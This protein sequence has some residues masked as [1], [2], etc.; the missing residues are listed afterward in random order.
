MN[1][2]ITGG[3]G[4]IGYHL[5]KLLVS[6]EGYSV[7]IIDNLNSYYSVE[8]KLDRLRDLGFELDINSSRKPLLSHKYENLKFSKIDI[9]HSDELEDLFKTNF[10]ETVVNLAAQAGVRY[11]LEKPA[12]YIQSNV[13]GFMN[14]L[15]CCRRFRISHLLYASSSSVYGLNDEVPLSEKCV[16]DSP[17]S[18]YAASKKSNELMAHSYSYLFNIRTTGLR[19]FTVYGPWGRP[20]MA[21]FM[22][23]KSILKGDAI[24]VY[25]QGNMF[26]DFTFIDDIVLG[27]RNL[28]IV[29][30]K[31]YDNSSINS[32][33][34]NHKIPFEVFNIGNSCPVNLM[35]F[36]N[37]IEKTLNIQAKLNYLPLQPGDVIRTHSNSDKLYAFTSFRP[38]VKTEEGI[39]K[40]VNWYLDYY[41]LN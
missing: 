35:S 7:Y 27:I 26:R 28:I 3:A 33:K 21:L 32:L 40:F 15:E 13:L 4:F 23:V 34:E 19:F 37:E 24:D 30:N 31:S 39:K 29:G 20:D 36:I 11:S 12:D 14:V 9:S 6:I 38:L 17:I 2:L 22:F 10:F 8:L 41:K 5:A 1:V 25:N 18:I 16:T